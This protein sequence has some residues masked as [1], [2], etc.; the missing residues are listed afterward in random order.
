MLIHSV[1]SPQQELE[2]CGKPFLANTSVICYYKEKQ[3]G[4]FLA[5]VINSHS[6]EWR[7]LW[8][9]NHGCKARGL[10]WGTHRSA[11]RRTWTFSLSFHTVP[12]IA[13]WCLPQEV[14]W[15]PPWSAAELHC[16][17]SPSPG[18]SLCGRGSLLAS[19]QWGSLK[20]KKEIILM[21]WCSPL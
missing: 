18:P 6:N 17:W 20:K 10:N 15:S 21:S 1:R 7:K 19:L 12:T 5:L 16:G 2:M 3:T 13:Q 14:T 8:L 4:E 9:W 11:W